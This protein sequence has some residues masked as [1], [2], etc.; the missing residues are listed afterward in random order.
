VLIDVDPLPV[1]IFRKFTPAR[2]GTRVVRDNTIEGPPIG[3]YKAQRPIVQGLHDHSPLMHLTVVKTAELN[4]VGELGFP[5]FDPVLDV[6][7]VHVARVRAPWK[8]ATAV[9]CA[10][11]TA[12]GRRNSARFA[13]DIERFPLLVL[14]QRHDA[15]VASEATRGIGS[16]GRAVF[17]LTPPCV[18]ISQ[19][20]NVD[21]DND[22]LAITSTCSFRSVLQEAFCYSAESIGATGSPGR[23]FIEG[24][25]NH[26]FRQFRRTSFR[27]NVLRLRIIHR[28]MQCFDE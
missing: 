11:R 1:V 25:H 8:T 17:K 2:E 24:L 27:G 16:Q 21:V 10:E 5:S 4:Q 28:R 13:S 23:P 14:R 18:P 19:G 9:T 26:P 12:N 3:S 15:G 22:L 20:F 6:M 7:R